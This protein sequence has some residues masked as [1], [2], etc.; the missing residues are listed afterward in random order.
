MISKD[1]S[2]ISIWRIAV[3]NQYFLK[4]IIYQHYMYTFNRVMIKWVIILRRRKRENRHIVCQTKERYWLA[5]WWIVTVTAYDFRY[6][7]VLYHLHTHNCVFSLLNAIY[8]DV[9][10]QERAKT[11]DQSSVKRSHKW[12]IKVNIIVTD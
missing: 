5:M 3:S 10:T 6:D 2:N 12:S 8:M 9:I 11:E 4:I 7:G 1:I